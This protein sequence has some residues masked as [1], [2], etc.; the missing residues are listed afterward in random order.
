MN[1]RITGGDETSSL[2]FAD[3]ESGA[4]IHGIAAADIKMRPNDLVR[5]SIDLVSHSLDVTGKADFYVIHPITG[6]R[7]K[8]R[9]IEF[10]G[11]D[12]WHA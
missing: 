3:A 8:V 6:E 10:E 11:G 1:V 4:R 5:A 7:R 2:V 12:T 9:S